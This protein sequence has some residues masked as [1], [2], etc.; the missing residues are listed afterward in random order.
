MQVAES[1]L[2]TRDVKDVGSPCQYLSACITYGLVCLLAG[3]VPGSKPTWA[4]ATHG[5]LIPIRLSR[6]KTGF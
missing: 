5:Y 6:D 4:V 3:L 1:P 2:T